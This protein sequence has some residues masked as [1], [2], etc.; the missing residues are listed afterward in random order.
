MFPFVIADPTLKSST[1]DRRSQCA[2][3]VRL[4]LHIFPLTQHEGLRR[5]TN[6]ELGERL[7]W[8][9]HNMQQDLKEE[10]EDTTTLKETIN[11]LQGDME[12]LVSELSVQGDLIKTKDEQITNLLKQLDQTM[13]L[14]RRVP[15]NFS[16]TSI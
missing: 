2:R 7:K 15:R 16:W 14:L 1:K 8:R 10:K 13:D 9:L 3:S 6:E 12:E 11:Q 5:R 4:I